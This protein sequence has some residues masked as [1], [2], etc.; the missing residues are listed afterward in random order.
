MVSH[1]DEARMSHSHS[2]RAAASPSVAGSTRSSTVRGVR[3]SRYSKSHAGVISA[4]SSSS[5]SSSNDF[6]IYTRSGDVEIILVSG[7]KEARYLLHKLYLAQSSGWFEDVLGFGDGATVLSTGSASS[8][9]SVGQRVRFE[10]EQS[11]RDS[12]TPMLVLKV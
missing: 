8:A 5:G 4:S 11:K 12:A 2:N 7:K 6:P 1:P 10:L 3:H 9:N